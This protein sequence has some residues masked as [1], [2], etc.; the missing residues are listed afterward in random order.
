MIEAQRQA[1]EGWKRGGKCGQNVGKS[2]NERKKNK[3]GHFE[4]VIDRDGKTR[5][6]TVGIHRK[7]SITR[8]YSE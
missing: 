7:G 3:L 2:E 5:W 6:D 1:L 4:G 8:F